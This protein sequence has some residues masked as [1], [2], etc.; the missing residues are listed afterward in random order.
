MR[1][2]KIKNTNRRFCEP[3]NGEQSMVYSSCKVIFVWQNDFLLSF[4]N[5]YTLI[6]Q[7]GSPSFR[8]FFVFKSRYGYIIDHFHKRISEEHRRQ[9]ELFSMCKAKTFPERKHRHAP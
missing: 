2:Y 1:I 8:F 5:R 6:H 9:Y 7:N 3:F 4:S